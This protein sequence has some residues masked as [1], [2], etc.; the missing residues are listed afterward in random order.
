MTE[1]EALEALNALRSNVIGTQSA[2]WS[3]AMYP[4]VA[5][6]N[7]AG[8]EQFDPTE[9][10]LREHMD[11]YGGAGG[12]PGNLRSEPSPGWSNPVGLTQGLALNMRKYLADPSPKNRSVVEA[13]LE[14]VKE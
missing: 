8:F 14:R 12:Y 7:E 9:A 13:W 4:F 10:Q 6:L 5:I 3:N 11:C 2:S 1:H